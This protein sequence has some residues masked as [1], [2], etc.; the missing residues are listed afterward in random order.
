MPNYGPGV[1]S[2]RSRSRNQGNL[3]HVQSQPPQAR[4]RVKVGLGNVRSIKEKVA[5]VCDVAF[6][7]RLDIFAVVESWSIKN[8]SYTAVADALFT[9]KKFSIIDIPRHHSRGR[10]IVLFHR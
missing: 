2:Y 3:L 9:L 5:R 1:T 7:N 10:G 8:A 6:S 4:P